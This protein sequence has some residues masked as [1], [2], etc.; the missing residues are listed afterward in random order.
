M[1][2][3]QWRVVT[4]K[5]SER[6][7]AINRAVEEIG[8]GKFNLAGELKYKKRGPGRHTGVNKVDRF[9]DRQ[10]RY[11]R[12]LTGWHETLGPIINEALNA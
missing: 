1:F 8:R 10:E 4:L 7:A 3:E 5:Q 9:Q 2:K 12:E 6:Q 11:E